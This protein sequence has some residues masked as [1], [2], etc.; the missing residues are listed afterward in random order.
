MP[1]NLEERE[2]IL[3]S[4]KLFFPVETRRLSEL[5]G[6]TT[7]KKAI[8]RTDTNHILGIHGAKYKLITNED[9][10]VPLEKALA[11]NPV[12]NT[13]GMETKDVIFDQGAKVLRVYKFPNETSLIVPPS[14]A[15]VGDIVHM[16]LR[17]MN[18]YDGTYPFGV[19]LRA[20]RLICDNG[21]AIGIKGTPT[22]FMKHTA[23]ANPANFMRT[24]SAMY[25]EYL[26]AMADWRR[27][28]KI[29]VPTTKVL[30]LIDSFTTSE[31]V[32][33][34]MKQQIPKQPVPEGASWRERH[35]PPMVEEISLWIFY[36]VLTQWMTHYS[37]SWHGYGVQP[38]NIM[39]QR[40]LVIKRFMNSQKEVFNV[41]VDNTISTA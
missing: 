23:G 30:K 11:T 20:K 29:I 38:E 18:S 14:D 27:W 6:M 40:E 2:E 36:N 13:H 25:S 15:Q 24:F 32:R 26:T 1:F 31:K 5:T 21:M 19:I 9:L 16:E 10:F 3:P 22:K 7:N 8:V 4:S 12:F 39:L 41:P 17:A 35:Y 37:S 33:R 28:A 34:H